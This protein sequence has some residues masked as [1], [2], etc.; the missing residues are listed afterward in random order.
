VRSETGNPPPAVPT[1]AAFNKI[2]YFVS[3]IEKFEHYL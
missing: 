2:S 3:Q 1:V